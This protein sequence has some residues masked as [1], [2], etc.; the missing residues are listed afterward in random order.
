MVLEGEAGIELVLTEKYS[1]DDEELSVSRTTSESNKDTLGNDAW[2]HPFDNIM[3]EVLGD[4]DKLIGTAKDDAAK[5]NSSQV[6]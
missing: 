1:Y 5:S 2:K 3:N 6:V 4:F